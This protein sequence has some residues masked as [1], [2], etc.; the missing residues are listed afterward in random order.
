MIMED[1]KI[2]KLLNPPERRNPTVKLSNA[3]KYYKY[4]RNWTYNINECVTLKNEI[5][6]LI[7]KGHLHQYKKSDHGQPP[8]AY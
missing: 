2:I 7:C 4:H 3:N 5:E 6:E 1:V 8:Q